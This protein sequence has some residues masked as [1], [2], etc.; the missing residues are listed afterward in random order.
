MK[1][2]REVNG[3]NG[4]DMKVV[5]VCTGNTCRSPM[6]EAIFKDLVRD[7]EVVS[8]GI[9]ASYGQMATPNAIKVC[10]KY[11]LDLKN[12]F[13]QNIGRVNLAYDDLILTATD[14]HKNELL[15]AYPNL[16]IH[17]IRGYA[18]CEPEDIADPI[19]GDLDDY[20]KCFLDI[21]EA[22][23]KIVEIHDF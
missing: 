22:L 10:E 12:H 20:E 2:L 9:Y 1:I 18:G 14:L 11:G 8:A 19:G 17:T 3:L 16:E 21:R 13:S 6:A 5:F 4:D 15:N 7:V 23:E